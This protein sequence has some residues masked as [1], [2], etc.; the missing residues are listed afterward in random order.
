M[1]DLF[2]RLLP[3]DAH[4]RPAGAPDQEGEARFIA[5]LRGMTGARDLTE[6]GVAAAMEALTPSQRAQLLA[7][8]E[9][10]F[11]RRV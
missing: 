8:G 5:M 9:K 7:E 4:G 3:K 10:V 6:A 11:A 1:S 2:A